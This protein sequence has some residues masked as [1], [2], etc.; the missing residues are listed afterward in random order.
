M[1]GLPLSLANA[2]QPSLGRRARWTR[3]RAVTGTPAAPVADFT[4][5]ARNASVA[6]T[7][8]A[9]VPALAARAE[10]RYERDT[11]DLRG[12]TVTAAG[13]LSLTAFG[14]GAR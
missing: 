4:V 1:N 6:A 13:G 5:S 14:P 9:G 7:R 11:V 12:A 10:G 8:N 2:S 3:P